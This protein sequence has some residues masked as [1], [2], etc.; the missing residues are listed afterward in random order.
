MS[1]LNSNYIILK[2]FNLLIECHSGN[3]DLKSYI[4][5]VKRTTLDPLFSKNM[6]YFIDLCNVVVT[7]SIDDIKLYNNFTDDN[8]KSDKKRKVALLT[9]SPN[10]MVFSTL[11]KNSNTQKLK[12]IEIFSTKESAFH[13]INSSLNKEEILNIFSSIQEYSER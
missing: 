4:D 13:W 8:F 1:L 11:F 3:L 10:Q 12:E 2:E 6:N 7:A 5:F 9:N